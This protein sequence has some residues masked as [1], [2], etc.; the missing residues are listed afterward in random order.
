MAVYTSNGTP[1]EI[2]GSEVGPDGVFFTD[3]GFQKVQNLL[4]QGRHHETN[5]AQEQQQNLEAARQ[6]QEFGISQQRRA[7]ALTAQMHAL[8]NQP[9]E[10][11][12]AA[13][14][15]LREKWPQIRTQA[16]FAQ[17]N[18][19]RQADQIRL[20]QY[21][22]RDVVQRAEPMMRGDLADR[23]A[24]AREDSRFN[25]LTDDDLVSVF[26]TLWD[27]RGQVFSY[28]N[29]QFYTDQSTV[30]NML[31]HAVVARNDA[32]AQ[33][34]AIEH[35]AAAVGGA[36]QPTPPAVPGGRAPA[37]AGKVTAGSSG[38]AELDPEDQEEA[39]DAWFDEQDFD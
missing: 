29:G 14:L 19:Q 3:E 15:D 9:E 13:A 17:Q 35:N 37:P 4:A 21:E 18:A 16:E 8:M 10:E 12:Y 1:Y 26:S 22:A 7:D 32:I 24:I 11:F 6:A 20:Q 2:E 34:A 23:V 36:A 25:V 28:H 38:A 31:A 33:Q 39:V 30:E 5:W 27:Q